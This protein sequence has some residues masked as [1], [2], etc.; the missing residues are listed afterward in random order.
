MATHVDRALP[1]DT[2]DQIHTLSL[3]ALQLELD[4]LAVPVHLLPDTNF[5]DSLTEKQR[6]ETLRMSIICWKT[7]G[8]SIFPRQYQIE[9]SLAM[10]QGQDTIIDIG[11]GYGKTLCMILP[12]LLQPNSISIVISPLRRLQILQVEEFTRWGLKAIAINQDT[13]KDDAL[14]MVRGLL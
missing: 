9:A 4:Q 3:P 11:T 8:Y 12:L 7:S 13:P 10:L 1:N 2:L 5:M 14:Y 6:M